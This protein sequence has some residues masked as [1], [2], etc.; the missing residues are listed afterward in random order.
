[1]RILVWLTLGFGAACGSC[2]YLLPNEPLWTLVTLFGVLTGVGFVLGRKHEE[3]NAAALVFLGCA[4]GLCWWHM[5]DTVYI[6]PVRA[7]DGTGRNM[8]FTACDYSME[9]Q[10]GTSVYAHVVL[11]GKEYKARVYMDEVFSCGPGDVIT[12]RFKLRLTAKDAEGD[13]VSYRSSGIF[14]TASASGEPLIRKADSVPLRYRP[15]VMREGIAALI[16]RCFPEDTSGFSKALL[17]GDKSDLSYEVDTDLKLSGIKHIVAVSGLHVSILCGA[18]YV[19]TGKRRFIT[20]LIGI[21]VMT[22]F[23]AIVG[24]SPSITR[25]AIMMS[26]MLMATLFQKEYDSPTALA[27][28]A[29]VM[30]IC[31][32][33]VI[34]SVSFQLSFGCMLGI[35]LFSEPLKA[36]LLSEGR[37]G[38]AEGR[39]WKSKCK[40]RLA[41]SISVSLCAMVFTTPLVAYY[42]HLISLVSVV[43]NL[44]VL[45]AVTYI[46]YAIMAV[47]LLGSIWVPL[48]SIVA[49]VISWLIRYVLAVAKILAAL[50]FAAVY[51]RSNWIIVWVV[52]CYCLLG[53][54][55]IWKGKRVMLSTLAAVVSLCFA[56]GCSWYSSAAADFQ[57]TVLDVGQGQSIILEYEGKVFVV[58]CGGDYDEG[59]ANT[60]AETLLSRGIERIDGLILTHFDADH[61]GG[62]EMLMSRIDVGH[63]FVPDYEQNQWT[64]ME[65]AFSIHEQTTLQFG[66]AVMTLFPG[67]SGD[68]GNESSLCVLFQK[69][70]CDILITGDRSWKGE[71]ELIGQKVLPDLE[72]LVA[73][74]HGSNNSTCSRL[75][76]VTMPETVIISCGEDNPYGHPGKELLQRLEEAGS[77][78]LRTDLEGTII[79]RG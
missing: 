35:I 73:G 6:S 57:M 4:A 9:T 45:W 11:E 70:N 48:A 51:T 71:M 36:W 12:G 14:L 69:E 32:P 53:L 38:T 21:S 58:D 75:L 67:K 46:F 26:L 22:L 2:A 68:G 72:V 30:F 54:Q 13:N 7:I 76:E 37:M 63:L 44:L 8:T 79:Y 1:M 43:T 42:Y 66:N 5:F 28:S 62:T 29:L 52:F 74:H 50:P 49:W 78:V 34:L 20:S 40:R 61:A 56:V 10:F 17:L 15:V 25:A 3:G 27:F 31:N 77:E 23:A 16:D 39:G 65:N 55:M 33:M 19:M 64:A 60:A 24:F 41:T 59:A 18:V 47:C